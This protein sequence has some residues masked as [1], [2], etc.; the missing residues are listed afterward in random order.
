MTEQVKKKKKKKRKKRKKKIKEV[1]ISVTMVAVPP[2]ITSKQG[3]QP[4]G[5]AFT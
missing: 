1:F 3:I 4:A 5:K 2:S